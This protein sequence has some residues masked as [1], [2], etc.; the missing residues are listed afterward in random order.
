M[1][2]PYIN[3]T[4]I[5]MFILF[6]SCSTT[7]EK[8]FELPKN[9]LS[10]IAHE[11][12]KTWKLAWRYNNGTRMNMS[13]CFLSY[14]ITY[15][16]DLSFKDNSEEHAN[17]GASLSGNWEITKDKKGYSFIKLTSAQLPELLKTKT[18]Y[19]YFKILQLTKDTLR[20]R[21]RHKQFS[22]E[23]TFE[24]TLVAEDIEVKDRDFHR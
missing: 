5:A 24:D 7:K 11:S 18:N 15:K 14:R 10:L 2:K 20:I 23:S 8:P 6:I 9:A 13:G 12:G 22:S 21:F 1:K 17:C 19:K 4:L 16:P 3:F